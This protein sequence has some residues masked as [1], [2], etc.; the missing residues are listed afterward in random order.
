MTDAYAGDVIVKKDDQPDFKDELNF[1]IFNERQRRLIL[2]TR[3][4]VLMPGAMIALYPTEEDAQ[5]LAVFDGIPASELHI[6]IAYLGKELSDDQA[7]L[8]RAF[9]PVFAKELEP[10]E[11]TVYRFFSP[12]CRLPR[13]TRWNI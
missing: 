13:A 6:T 10:L 7:D 11:A 2:A 3:R 8:I 1:Y 4:G 12:P 9:L 5:R